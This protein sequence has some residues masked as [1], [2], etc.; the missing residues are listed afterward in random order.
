MTTKEKLLKAIDRLDEKQADDLLRVIN[1]VYLPHQRPSW[2]GAFHSGH[3]HLAERHEE[4]IREE[5][6]RY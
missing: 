4:I 3:G 2:V 5:L 6:G 1:G